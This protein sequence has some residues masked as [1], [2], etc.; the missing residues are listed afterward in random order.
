METSGENV[1]DGETRKIGA[2]LRM[3]CWTVVAS[4]ALGCSQGWAW[5]TRREIRRD[6]FSTDVYQVYENGRWV[7]TVRKDP[8]RSDTYRWEEPGGKVRGEVRKDPFGCN[9]LQLLDWQGR[10]TGEVRPDPF[11]SGRYRVYDPKG[12]LQ[13]EVRKDFFRDDVY[14]FEGRR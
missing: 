4:V 9:T 10:L 3:V 11:S 6:P 8:L 2:A 5:E 1:K 13:G 7:G 12:R 14:L